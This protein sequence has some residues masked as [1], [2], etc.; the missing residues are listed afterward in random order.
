MKILIS[1]PSGA[2]MYATLHT[3]NKV[4]LDTRAGETDVATILSRGYMIQAVL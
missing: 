2:Q 4:T 1:S 3:D